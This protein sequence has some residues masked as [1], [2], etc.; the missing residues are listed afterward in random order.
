MRGWIIVLAILIAPAAHAQD[1]VFPG[2]VEARERAVLATSLDGLLA[3]ILFRGGE[4]VEKGQPLFRLD[5]RALDLDVTSAQAAVAAQSARAGNARQ[6]LERL[7]QL[8]QRQ[9]TSQASLDEAAAR[10]AAAE[11]DLEVARVRLEQAELEREKA[12]IRAPISGVVSRPDVALGAFLEAKAGPP[13][14]EIVQLDPVLVAYDVPYQTRLQ[15]IRETG[16]STV[17]QM[18]EGLVL[19]VRLNNG[20]QV[21]AGITPE[22]ASA[23]VNAADGTLTIWADVP[24]PDRVLRPGMR[25]VV[26]A[27]IIAQSSGE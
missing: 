15:T 23:S 19:T 6:Q 5:T 11:A 24:N 18:F 12:T 22:F 27:E 2:M 1:L 26:S 20:E 4:T 14:A 3:Q 17:Q 8:S 7:T 16:A 25:V 10:R 13:L 9:V 21:A